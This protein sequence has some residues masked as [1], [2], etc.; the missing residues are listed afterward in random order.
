MEWPYAVEPPPHPEN[1]RPWDVDARWL[2][3]SEENNEW[4]IEED[5]LIPA[6]GLRPRASY[7]RKW[8]HSSLAFLPLVF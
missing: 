2:L 3:Y 4:M 5:F 1:G 7:T 8:H 6:G